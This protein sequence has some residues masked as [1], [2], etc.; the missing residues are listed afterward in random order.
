[1]AGDWREGVLL[2]TFGPVPSATVRFLA[3]AGM[4]GAPVDGSPPSTD[5]RPPEGI[6]ALSR[7]ILAQIY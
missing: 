7:Q 2:A 1:M 6:F 4:L 5:G 3:P